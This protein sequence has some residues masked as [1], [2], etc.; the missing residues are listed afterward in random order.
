MTIT[1]TYI[2]ENLGLIVRGSAFIRNLIRVIL[3]QGMSVKGALLLTEI[4]N[5]CNILAQNVEI[6]VICAI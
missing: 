2:D 1:L 6:A 5:V 4:Q 3:W